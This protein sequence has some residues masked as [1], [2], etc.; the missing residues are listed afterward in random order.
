MPEAPLD[1]TTMV[2]AHLVIHGLVQGVYFRAS[3]AEVARAHGVA[4][5]VRNVAQDVEAVL[6]GPRAA[7]DHVV[8][9][10][11][12]GP[13]RAEVEDVDVTWDEPEGLESF[14]VRH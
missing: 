1:D 12:Q 4:G 10:C 13:P 2:R 6:E 8:A 14:A 7:V 11:H 3:T 5:W 9:W